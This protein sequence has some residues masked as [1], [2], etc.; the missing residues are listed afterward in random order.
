MEQVTPVAGWSDFYEAFRPWSAVERARFIW[1]LPEG[2][3]VIT[4][5]EECR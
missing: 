5:S 4:E 2:S 1:R 3:V